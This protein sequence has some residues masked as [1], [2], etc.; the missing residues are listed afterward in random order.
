MPYVSTKEV[1]SSS[2]VTIKVCKVGTA[3]FGSAIGAILLTVSK[4][5][6]GEAVAPLAPTLYVF[7]GTSLSAA[8]AGAASIEVG[9]VAFVGDG[10]GDRRK[11]E[12][13]RTGGGGGGGERSAVEECHRER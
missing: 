13:A 11:N 8:A 3:S 4:V 9:A 10:R 1:L 12:E 7:G 5:K 6:P 2:G